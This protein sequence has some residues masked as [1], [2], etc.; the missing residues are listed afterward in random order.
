M[1]Q[2]FVLSDGRVV[3]GQWE[4]PTLENLTKLSLERKVTVKHIHTVTVGSD[5]QKYLSEAAKPGNM[6]ISSTD[7]I[8]MVVMMFGTAWKALS[9]M[10]GVTDESLVDITTKIGLD[11][12]KRGYPSDCIYQSKIDDD[13]LLKV[14]EKAKEKQGVVVNLE[15]MKA[16]MMG[17]F[18]EGWKAH[19]A[20]I[21]SSN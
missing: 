21:I 14:L 12:S 16:A 10:S 11:W 7:Y 4:I 3:W 2:I 1:Y 17:I 18:S 15:N 13:N 6:R 19:Q 9:D 20:Q 8:Y 5:L